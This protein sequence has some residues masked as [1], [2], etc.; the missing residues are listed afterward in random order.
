MQLRIHRWMQTTDPARSKLID[1]RKLS[2][3]VG[4]SYVDDN[5]VK[6]WEFY[7]DDSDVFTSIVKN[8]KWGGRLSA[9]TPINTKPLFMRQHSS[10]F[11]SLE[12][13]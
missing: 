2:A 3:D 7:A 4:Y 11:S 12:K 5:G 1:E 13:L 9:R 10:S 6:M 8:E